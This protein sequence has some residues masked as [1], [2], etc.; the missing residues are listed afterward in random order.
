MHYQK[1]WCKYSRCT[2]PVN[3][4]SS[5][6]C[7]CVTRSLRSGMYFTLSGHLSID[8]H[9]PSAY[10]PHGSYCVEEYRIIMEEGRKRVKPHIRVLS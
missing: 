9:V 7:V 2:V 1:D 8:E 10:W 4:L 3:L 5:Y 6:E